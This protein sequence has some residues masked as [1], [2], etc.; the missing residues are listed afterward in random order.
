M[1]PPDYDSSPIYTDGVGIGW[2]GYG[3]FS[4]WPSA[5]FQIFDFKEM[6]DDRMSVLPQ[7]DHFRVRARAHYMTPEEIAEAK[8]VI[9]RESKNG[10]SD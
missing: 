6:D 7:I 9:N 3:M 10:N 5:C 4:E 1:K 8:T 2:V